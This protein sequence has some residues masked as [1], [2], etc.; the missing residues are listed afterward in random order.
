MSKQFSQIFNAMLPRERRAVGVVALIAIFRMFGLFALLPVLA[1]YAAAL[2]GATPTLIGIAVG[3]YGLTQAALQ[4]PF[5]ALSDRIGRVPV[6]VFGL[7]LFAA[8]SVLAAQ[9]DTI[10]GVIAGRLLQG[11][12]AISATLTALLAD[13]T[14]EEIRTRSMAIF[15]VAIGSSFLLALIIGPMIAAASSVRSLFWV[16]AG[17]AVVAGLLL[18]LLPKGIERPAQLPD[19]SVRQALRPDLLRLDL[20]IF[21]LHA[22]LTASFVA[23]PFLLRNELQLPLDSHWK[24]YIG[25]L[26]VSLAGTVPLIAADERQGKSS[27]LAMAILLLVIGQLALAVA[28]SSAIVVFAALAVFFAGFNFLEAGLPA[29]LSIRA[30]G[31]IRGAALGVFS[32]S[33][34]LGAFAGGLIGGRFLAVGNPAAVFIVCAMLASIW[35]AV[36]RMSPDYE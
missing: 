8:G 21:V 28:G 10:H 1:I 9:S 11:A 15:G 19:R 31:E 34:F 29:R 33:Q 30:A 17:M 14:R 35:L 6:I 3:G 32:S 24:I 13:A 18:G 5:G 25:A 22:L 12:G 16:A 36:H 26:L 4:I 23:L 2:E 27:T 20:Y 7:V